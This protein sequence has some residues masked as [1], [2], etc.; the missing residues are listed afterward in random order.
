MSDVF[1]ATPATSAPQSALFVAWGQL[2]SFD[3]FRNFDNASEP[4]DE[5]C[6]DGADMLFDVWCPEGAA[7]GD[8]PFY[9]Y[10]C[11]KP[12]LSS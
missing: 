4:Y 11:R 5:P 10:W 6:S 8:I 2:V 3:I 7:S 12:L 9:R 1:L